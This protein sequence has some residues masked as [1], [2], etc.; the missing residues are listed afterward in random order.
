MRVLQFVRVGGSFRRQGETDV[1]D[2][3]DMGV[4]FLGDV[5][6]GALALDRGRGCLIPRDGDEN[7]YELLNLN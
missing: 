3:H 2:V 7:L 4:I 6:I 1:G 5:A